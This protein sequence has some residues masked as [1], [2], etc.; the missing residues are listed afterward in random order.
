MRAPLPPKR[1]VEPTI[2][3]LAGVAES[4]GGFLLGAGGGVMFG[5]AMA[6]FVALLATVQLIVVAVPLVAAAS[7]TLSVLFIRGSRLRSPVDRAMTA[8][9]CAVQAAI[10][11]MCLSIAVSAL[12]L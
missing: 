11:W 7:I 9:F 8:G 12:T 2:G 6:V 4:L 3:A 5:V 1:Y 10:L